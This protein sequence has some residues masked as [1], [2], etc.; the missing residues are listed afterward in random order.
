MKVI[1]T[2]IDALNAKLQQI[3]LGE[4]ESTAIKGGALTLW[5]HA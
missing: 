3:S 5:D 2:V 1:G 4:L